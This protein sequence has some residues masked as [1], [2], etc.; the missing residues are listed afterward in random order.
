[1]PRATL[2]IEVDYDARHTD[3]EKLATALTDQIRSKTV[4]SRLLPAVGPVIPDL[5]LVEE[6]GLET[7]G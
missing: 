7:E 5:F 6:T 2:K 4:L 3:A 1:M